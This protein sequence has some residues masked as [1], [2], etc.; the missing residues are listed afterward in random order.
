MPVIERNRDCAHSRRRGVRNRREREQS[1]VGGDRSAERIDEPPNR[2]AVDR[3]GDPV[4]E[5]VDVIRRERVT[6]GGPDVCRRKQ[7]RVGGRDVIRQGA[8]DIGVRRLDARDEAGE[9][10]RHG[11]QGGQAGHRRGAS[12]DNAARQAG[13]RGWHRQADATSA[14]CEVADEGVDSLLGAADQEGPQRRGVRSAAAG[15][16]TGSAHWPA[17]STSRSWGRRSP[18]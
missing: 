8:D 1:D 12:P 3:F 4:Q 15:T 2:V 18:S 14:R 10:G 6:E 5:Q 9:R 17:R 7:R 13:A 16:R 11:R